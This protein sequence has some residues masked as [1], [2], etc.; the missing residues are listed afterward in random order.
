MSDAVMPPTVYPAM[1]PPK[2]MV[3]G[4]SVNGWTKLSAA[5][6]NANG[7]P[8]VSSGALTAGVLAQVLNITGPG[9]LEFLSVINNNATS[10][11][12]R[13]KLV[14]DGVTVLDGTSAALTAAGTACLVGNLV[15]ISPNPIASLGG[16]PFKTS[17]VL[18]VASSLTEAAPFNVQYVYRGV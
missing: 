14:I 8:S 15:W 17:C 6:A 7:L 5:A 12:M 4:F 16:I 11:T 3:N 2:V 1:L 9:V 18:S 10:R 13:I